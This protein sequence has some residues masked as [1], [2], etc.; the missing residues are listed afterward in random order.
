MPTAALLPALDRLIEAALHAE[1]GRIERRMARGLRAAFSLQGAA[2]A[3]G[4]HT[5]H[6]IDGALAATRA[7]FDAALE[8]GAT[9]ALGMGFAD[10]AAMLGVTLA[11]AAAYPG[12]GLP[13]VRVFRDA[14]AQTAAYVTD[15]KA[16]RWRALED[17]TRQRLDKVLNKSASEG[18]GY[19]RTERAIRRE[20]RD[21]A[22]SRA[23]M[24]ARTETANAYEGARRI[25]AQ[26]VQAE[27]ETVEQRWLVTYQCCDI[28]AMNERA[29]WLPL[30]APYPSGG[31]RP[32][33]HPNCRCSVQFRT[34]TN[35]QT[36]E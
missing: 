30:D 17:T 12:D 21:M 22:D 36:E 2:V 29:G 28:C 33:E 24:I 3:K 19:A 25:V 13:K 31:D 10:V 34:A 7:A 1:L 8:D 15:A 14:P 9:R 4:Y 35:S 27:G 6:G 20:F 11:E 23:D 5:P 32:P 18:W 16:V 26:G